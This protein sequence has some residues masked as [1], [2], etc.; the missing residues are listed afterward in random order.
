M[1]SK[2]S[3]LPVCQP[4][5]V[6]DST[7]IELTPEHLVYVAEAAEMLGVSVQTIHRRIA[8]GELPAFRVGDVGPY[9]IPEH[10]VEGLLRP[11]ETQ[12]GA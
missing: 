3:I 4:E 8:A 5:C 7:D 1:N 6:A 11:V 9:R 2:R 10:A 12:E